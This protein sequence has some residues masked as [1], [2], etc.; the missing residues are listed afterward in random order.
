MRPATA[1]DLS[2]LTEAFL[3]SLR[4]AITAARGCWDEVLERAQFHEQLDIGGTRI[5]VS[6]G[7]EV[8]FVTA[9]A[10][11]TEVFLHTL[12]I[13]PQHQGRGI[14]TAVTRE[15]MS[16]ARRRGLAIALTVLKTNPS[17]RRLYERLGF[18]VVEE[19]EHHHRLRHPGLSA[20]PAEGSR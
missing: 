1:A 11:A 8:G 4:D 14:G 20:P 6:A 19:L 10:S 5:I 2:F 9:V 17:A 3:I 13:L 12:C 15:V 16:G 18:V 7:R